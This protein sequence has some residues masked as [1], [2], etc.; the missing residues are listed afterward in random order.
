MGCCG[1]FSSEYPFFLLF[2]FF[3]SFF[4]GWGKRGLEI[5]FFFGFF[6]ILKKEKKTPQN[7]EEE[8]GLGFEREKGEGVGVGG[9]YKIPTP[10]KFQ[11][12]PP[13]VQPSLRIPFSDVTNPM[14]SL[15]FL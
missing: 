10:K 1:S 13:I 8:G 7:G 3:F 5:C 6:F 12:Q 11:T 15:S 4:V 2:F 14:S 9:L